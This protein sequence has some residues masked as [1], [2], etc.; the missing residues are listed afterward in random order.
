MREPGWVRHVIWWQVYPLGFT[1]AEPAMLAGQQP[2]HRLPKLHA[3]LDYAKA[4]WSSLND[5]NFYELAAALERHNGFLGTF[6][7]LTIVGNHDVTRLESKLT[8][9]DQL[10]LALVVL[11]T[12]GGTPS[13]YYGDEQ[14][15]RGIKEDRVGGDDAVRPATCQ[16]RA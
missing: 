14:A 12:V 16:G 1:G 6:R 11:L 5:A 2:V 10:P 8:N 7:P 4:V 9:P 3:W 15:S 13:I